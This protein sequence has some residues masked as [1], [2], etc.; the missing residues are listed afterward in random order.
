M[1]ACVYYRVKLDLGCWG[2]IYDSL[3]KIGGKLKRYV[4]LYRGGGGKN[5]QNWCYV[6]FGR[7]L[8]LMSIMMIVLGEWNVFI[9]M[10]KGF[11]CLAQQ[12]HS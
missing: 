7:S 8:S 4:L 11:P 1:F 12:P 5:E 9:S 3:R 10:A 2:V 6:I